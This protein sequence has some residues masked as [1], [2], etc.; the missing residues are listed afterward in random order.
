MGRGEGGMGGK[1]QGRR[2]IIRR[3]KIGRDKNGIGNREFKELICT[4]HAHE[5]RW[6]ECWRV[7]GAGRREGKG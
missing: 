4:A 2:S 3:H 5:L 7:A 1:L 6:G